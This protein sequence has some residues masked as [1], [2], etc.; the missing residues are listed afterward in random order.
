MSRHSSSASARGGEDVGPARQEGGQRG[1]EGGHVEQ[2]AA[3][4]VDVVGPHALD[5]GHERALGHEGPAREQGAVGAAGEGGRVHHE[6]GGGLVDGRRPDR[7]LGRRRPGRPRSR[8][9]PSPSWLQPQG[10]RTG[11]GPGLA[12]GLADLGLLPED[13]RRGRSRSIDE[14][15]LVGALAP[16]GGAEDGADLGRGQEPLE[17]AVAV[18]SEPQQPVALAHAGRR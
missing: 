15:E 10:L 11:V 13:D 6:H 1:H 9:R 14:G 3:V 2:R 17:Q 8:R 16:V 7:W 12:Q 18:L 4:Q 5:L